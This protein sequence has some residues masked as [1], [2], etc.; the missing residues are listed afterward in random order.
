[1]ASHYISKLTPNQPVEGAKVLLATPWARKVDAPDSIAGWKPYIL[2]V[3]KKF[4]SG[5]KSNWHHR[6]SAKVQTPITPSMSIFPANFPR[7]PIS[8]T[9]I[10]RTLQQL[11][12]RSKS[13][14]K[15][16]PRHLPSKSG[17]LSTNALEG[18][19]STQPV[20]SISLSA[21]LMNSTIVQVWINC[22]DA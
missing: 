5:D 12:Q 3:I 9:T 1:L 11:L 13:C 6:M 10:K 14:L 18:I 16:S 4:K 21:F 19:L 17:V 8:S 15:S 22:F 2:D 7:L 20:T